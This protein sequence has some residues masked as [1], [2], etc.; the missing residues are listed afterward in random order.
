MNTDIDT[1]IENKQQSM[2]DG[3]DKKTSK[4]NH[5]TSNYESAD[6]E[7]SVNVYDE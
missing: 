4:N 3:R 6:K 7:P 5:N 1:F 2:V